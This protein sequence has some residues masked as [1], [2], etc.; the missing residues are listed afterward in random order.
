MLQDPAYTSDL[1]K[2]V[3]GLFVKSVGYTTFRRVT[4]ILDERVKIDKDLSRSEHEPS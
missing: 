2:D 4:E 3:K 1:N